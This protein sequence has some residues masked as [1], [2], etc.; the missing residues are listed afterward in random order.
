[1]LT[2]L[3]FRSKLY[4][5]GNLLVDNDGLHGMVELCSKRFMSTGFHEIYVIGFQ[6]WGP[7]G[8]GMEVRYSG[9][10]TGDK[11]VF[12]RVAA[13]PVQTGAA[14][15]GGSAA[16]I[17]AANPSSYAQAA[18]EIG[19][20]SSS[21]VQNTRLKP[22]SE[23]TLRLG[24]D[25]KEA[26]SNVKVCLRPVMLFL[27]GCK[28][29]VETYLNLFIYQSKVFLLKHKDV[30]DHTRQITSVAKRNDQGA[31][32]AS[33]SKL[34]EIVQ[35]S[36]LNM[37]CYLQIKNPNKTN[38]AQHRQ[39]DFLRGWIPLETNHPPNEDQPR[40]SWFSRWG[41]SSGRSTNSRWGPSVKGKTEGDDWFGKWVSKE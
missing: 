7:A 29:S 3:C 40:D 21:R 27:P 20:S 17:A 11:L 18:L 26:L 23:N 32:E 1:M 9:A 36:H 37:T 13:P 22:F 14:G 25:E 24:T 38:H 5:D 33:S 41:G 8:V 30:Q 6:Q 2:S 35:V 16:A 15:A 12:M 28:R 34:F 19:S 10:D 31:K 39:L 4:V